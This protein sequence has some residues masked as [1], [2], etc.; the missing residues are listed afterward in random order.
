MNIVVQED[1]KIRIAKSG[2]VRTFGDYDKRKQMDDPQLTE[3]FDH[4]WATG[5]DEAVSRSLPCDLEVARIRLKGRQQEFLRVDEEQRQFR[6]QEMEFIVQLRPAGE[7]GKE[8][9]QL[10]KVQSGDDYP[11]TIFVTFQTVEERQRFRDIA[12]E[13]GWHD[14][15]LALSLLRDF[16]A[17]LD[18]IVPP[19]ES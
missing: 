13:L 1:T 14:E 16:M 9:T 19:R 17:K 2:P 6:H 12:M 5:L 10:W 11:K 8:L 7:S 18:K 4:A 15:Q 3:L